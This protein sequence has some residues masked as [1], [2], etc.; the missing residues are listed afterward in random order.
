[1]QIILVLETRSSA[2]TDFIYIKSA[3]DYFYGTRVAQISKVF[4][5]SKS[6]LIK[7]DKNILE[8]KNKYNG[9]SIVV[10]VADFDRENDPLNAQIAQYCSSNGY[11]LIWMNLCVEEV[12]LGKIIPDKLKSKTATDYLKKK[13]T[14]L[15]SNEHLNS[16]E[17]LNKHP[18]SN[19]LNV[20]D[21]FFKRI[22]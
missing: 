15:S 17:P 21:E 3:F 1:M 12:F 20:F 2:K 6:E 18:N 11:K 5:K 10:V 7:Q 9:E 4:A 22:T 19:F 16:V 13:Q 8:K 14:N